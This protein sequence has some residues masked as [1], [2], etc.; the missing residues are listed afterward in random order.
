MRSR[1]AGPVTVRAATAGGLA[2][3]ATVTVN[4]EEVAWY[5]A[6]TSGT[7]LVD[8]SGHNQTAALTVPDN[9]ITGVSGTA[10]NLTGGYAKLPNGIV[11]SLNDFTIAAWVKINTLST[12]SRIFD[13]G[14]GTTSYM[15]LTPQANGAGGPLRF[16]ITTN[17]NGSEQQLNGPVLSTGVW[18]HIAVTLVGNTA[19]MY[20]NG[21]AVAST[22]GL[23]VHPAALGNTTLNYIGKSQYNDPAFMG[24]IDDFRIFSRGLSAAEVLRLAKP[25]I[26]TPAAA[27][28]NP[29]TTA[30]TTL[31]VLGSDVTAGEAA[32]TYTWST[33]G[34][35]PAAVIFSSNGTNAAKNTVATFTQPGTYNFQVTIDNPALGA[36]FAT[37]SSVSVTVNRALAT[38]TV[39]PPSANLFAGQTQPFTAIGIDQFGATLAVQP[40][41]VW[42]IDSGSVGSISTAGLYS[43]PTSAI[44]SATVRATSGLASGTAN[45]NVAWLQ[46]DLNGDGKLTGADLSALMTALSDLSAY[47]TQRGI[48]NADLLAIADI[49]RDNKITNAD[50]PALIGLLTNAAAGGG[51]GAESANTSASVATMP[52][53]S[54]DNGQIRLASASIMGPPISI[55]TKAD[56]I[57]T[58]QPVI[59]ASNGTLV[60]NPPKFFN[61]AEIVSQPMLDNRLPLATSLKIDLKSKTAADFYFE[62]LMDDGF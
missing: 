62:N 2:A 45:V 43:A 30:S 53:G 22:T 4:Y 17:G 60:W 59:A 14:T 15:F 7:T 8:S 29:V 58:S 12:W 5:Q 36:T 3:S 55:A 39:S 35:P 28:A 56:A 51:A 16:A 34:T 10:L 57:Q 32:L 40:A 48:S 1:T 33:T 38:I 49:D 6:D 52:A 25:A 18:Y 20:V 54:I 9:F 42:S 19:T 37:T 11:S 27:G 44:G 24:S 26:V 41:F 46:G 61:N 23:T 21:A 50:L 31:S 47:Q 13:F